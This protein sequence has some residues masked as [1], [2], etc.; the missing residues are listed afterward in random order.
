MGPQRW[1]RI[2]QLFDLA[3]DLPAEQRRAWLIDTCRDD[4]LLVDQVTALLHADG[5]GDAL[6]A[7]I[8]RSIEQELQTIRLEPSQRVGPWAVERLLASGGMGSVYLAQRSDQSY[9]QLAVIKVVALPLNEDLRERFRRE[10]QIPGDRA[11]PTLPACW[12]AA[13]CRAVNLTWSWNTS[14]AVTSRSSVISRG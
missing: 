11:T 1:Q 6:T 5:E 10:R 2:Q 4:P 12:T 3:V 9:E 14:R 13:R 7:R 8:G